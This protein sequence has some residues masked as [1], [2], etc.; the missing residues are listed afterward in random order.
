ML[1]IALLDQTMG[2]SELWGW[3]NYGVAAATDDD[4]DATADMLL[5]V[6]M[7]MMMMMMMKQWD[8]VLSQTMGLKIFKPKFAQIMV[9]NPKVRSDGA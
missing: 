3:A 6:M 7:M 2:L 5:M 8:D 9:F 4:T 1:V